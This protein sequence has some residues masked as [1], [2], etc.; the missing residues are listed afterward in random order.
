MGPVVQP[1]YPQQL[2]WDLR[3]T[4]AAAAENQEA[5]KWGEVP[6]SSPHPPFAEAIVSVP[7]ESPAGPV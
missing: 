2:L 6:L 3:E 1:E 7:A 4:D 5:S